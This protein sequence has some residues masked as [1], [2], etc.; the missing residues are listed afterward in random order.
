MAFAESLTTKEVR[1]LQ[2]MPAATLSV[3]S[4]FLSFPQANACIYYL[5][6]FLVDTLFG[7]LGNF[8]M[9]KVQHV[10]ERKN[11]NERGSVG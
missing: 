5:V 2:L 10:K 8:I 4:L 9:L 1:H 11:E 3:V 6:N 7:C